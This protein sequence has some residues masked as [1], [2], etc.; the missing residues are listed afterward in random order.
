VFLAAVFFA[1][2]LTGVF[3]AVAFFG[4]GLAAG[5]AASVAGLPFLPKKV[6]SRRCIFLSASVTED[7]VV[8]AM[9]SAVTG[10]SPAGR[11]STRQRLSAWPVRVLLMSLRWTSTRVSFLA[12]RSKR[13]LASSSTKRVSVAST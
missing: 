4:F 3:F 8:A 13:R 6:V 9:A 12:K 10:R 7:S 1:V 2:F 11:A 5:A